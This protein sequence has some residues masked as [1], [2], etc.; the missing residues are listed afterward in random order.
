MSVF[1]EANEDAMSVTPDQAATGPRVGF[2]QA[3]EN[4]YNA[5]TRASAMFGIENEMQNVEAEQMQKLRDAGIDASEVPQLGALRYPMYMETARYYE[6]GGEPE[7]AQRLKAYDERI[8]KLREKYPDMGLMT[9]EEIWSNVKSKAQ[10]YEQ[11]YNRSRTTIGGTVGN[12]IGGT[13]GAFNP[14]SDPLNTLTLNVGGMGRSILTRVAGQGI[15]QGAIETVNQALGVQ[16]QRRLLGLD[17]GVGDAVSRV[18]GA[19]PCKGLVRSL[20]VASVAFSRA[21]RST[22]RQPRYRSGHRCRIRR[23]SHVRSFLPTRTL[24]R[25]S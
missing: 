10:S 20:P 1:T 6:D 7:T 2:L 19:S 8:T 14:E 25:R 22:R 9:S 24:Q 18:T 21:L 12:F 11:E 23:L 13:V 3:F 4:S 5:Q 15:A 17:Y 16:E